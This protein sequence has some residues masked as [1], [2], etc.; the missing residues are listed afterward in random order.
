LYKAIEDFIE[1]SGN[2]LFLLDSPTGFGKTTAVI[3]IIKDFL[4][5]GKFADCKR[6][7]FFTNLKNNLPYKDL[8]EKL[9]DEDKKHILVAKSYRDS[10][11]ES[12][13]KVII[14]DAYK[15]IVSSREYK[16]LKEAIDGWTSIQEQIEQSKK[17]SGTQERLRKIKR[18]LDNRIDVC[19]IEF[20]K[21]LQKLLFFGKS[22]VEKKNFVK[23]NTWFRI[24]YPIS[25][26]EDYKVVFLTTKKFFLPM[27]VF[28]R[29][30]FYAYADSLI[31]D[32]V[33]F[34]DEFDATK[35]DV[36]SQ[37]IDNGLISQIDAVKLFKTIHYALQ[38]VEFPQNLLRMS[39]HVKSKVEGEGWDSP[40]NII[41]KNKA[42]F[43]EKYNEYNFDYL[44]KSV[45]ASD[46]KKAFL[47]DDGR[48]ITVFKDNSNKYLI[49]ELDE[50][51]NFTKLTARTTNDKEKSLNTILKEILYCISYFAEG[52]RRL[53][54]NYHYYKN[55]TKD[56]MR[57]DKY[58][59][60]EAVKTILEVFNISEE[61][62]SDYLFKLT[63]Q[64]KIE[65]LVP[66]GV[67]CRKGFKFTEV[68]D[69]N[70]HD[71]QSFAHTF[72]FD[73]TPED[74]M[75]MMSKSTKVIGVSATASLKTVI[76]NYDIDYIQK[77]IQGDL[78][79]LSP[80][81]H[82]RIGDNFGKTQEIY[83]NDVKVNVEVI[84]D[85]NCF[86]DKE[87][88]RS[89]LEKIYS[90]EFLDKNIQK[91]EDEKDFFHYF[92]TL[93]LAYLYN[94][95]GTNAIYSFIAFLNSHPRK[96]GSIDVDRLEEL[97]QDAATCNSFEYYKYSV[98]KSDAFDYEMEKVYN[99]LKDG[100]KHFV[101]STYQTV[102]SGKNIQYEIP[103]SL[104]NNIVFDKN[105]ERN[106]KDFDGV[107]LATPTHLLQQLNFASENK[108]KDISKFL[109]QQEYLR[110][111]ELISYGEMR[112]NVI[113][114]FKRIFF[115]DRYNINYNK[116]KDIY[117]HTAQYVIQAIGRICRCRHKNKE[118]FIFSDLEVLERL[119]RVKPELDSRLLNTEFLALLNQK[120]STKNVQ[121][122]EKLTSINKA[123]YM[124]ISQSARTVRASSQNVLKWRA[125]R[126]YVLKNP[127]A[128]FVPA[129]YRSW[130]FEF[131]SNQKGY[132]YSVDNK[133]S[134]TDLKFDT[135][136]DMKQVS[137]TDCDLPIMLAVPCIQELF[138][139]NKYKKA[140]DSN[141]F[142]MSISLY[143]QIYKGALGEVVGKEIIERQ[144]GIDLEELEDQSFYEYFDFKYNDVYFDF[145]HWNEFITD[146]DKYI[147]K[148]EW[149][150]NRIK[151]A[152]CIVVNIVKRGE[153]IPKINIGETVIQIPYL[154]DDETGDIDASMIE[155]IEEHL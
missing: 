104:I 19:E 131:D 13:N 84:D 71:L 10:I 12:F 17:D 70:Y 108:Y 96:G 72:N 118:I 50:Q 85:F 154:I 101:I 59:F 63:V 121:V 41:E 89:I 61:K 34:I 83:T 75:I 105:T 9:S 69:S 48:Y 120:V 90:G 52:V 149:K 42:K 113:N 82:K 66:E 64:E 130:Y 100:K 135:R 62:F 86:H 97:F 4:A 5:N 65:N 94:K 134:I 40:G 127:T 43:E 114:G 109:F 20:R 77:I 98:V 119:N 142:I 21:Y 138:E 67:E 116:N 51:E 126:E 133:F 132:S 23:E 76:G 112:Y 145:K 141:K 14:P 46:Y 37:I 143:Q 3:E 33:I 92:E 87:K 26:I 137:E 93:K 39:E 155:R 16:D 7:F 150:L 1:N 144:C 136:L 45:W 35:R 99:D 148:I 24:L 38:N 103:E 152:K 15:E 56:G 95:V 27:N 11:K 25:A 54:V 58:N 102:G 32:S 57:E 30:P 79:T 139:K 31:K 153:H 129:D 146:A 78:K 117:L 147:K 125:L 128:T 47:F 140:F 18:S 80:A 151:G 115:S 88:C 53:S 123:A 6:M 91:L 124:T 55:T 29:M 81:E 22:F 44:I 28:Y 110:L 60:E 111:N 73:T 74:L 122:L 68:E 107:Y 49:T 106:T 2:G 8:F 36:L